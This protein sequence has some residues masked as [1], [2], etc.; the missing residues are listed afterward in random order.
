MV[1]S[2]YNQRTWSPSVI[3]F[4]YLF[5]GS[6]RLTLLKKTPSPGII[7]ALWV[8]RRN[9]W[10]NVINITIFNIVITI[11]STLWFK[12]KKLF[13]ENK[14][15]SIFSILCL[16]SR[17]GASDSVT[18][19]STLSNPADAQNVSCLGLFGRDICPKSSA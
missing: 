17:R 7:A 6:E 5:F 1:Y 2:C 3:S 19:S 16:A 9:I 10:I 15:F 4:I 11:D 14:Y 18:D 12:T 13:Y 8:F